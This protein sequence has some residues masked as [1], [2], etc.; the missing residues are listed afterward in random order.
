MNVDAWNVPESAAEELRFESL[1]RAYNNHRRART[2]RIVVIALTTA[3]VLARCTLPLTAWKDTF[4]DGPAMLGIA[5]LVTCL[6]VSMEWS[7]R[8]RYHDCAEAYD[9]YLAVHRVAH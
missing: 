8:V 5:F 3:A 6:S 2:I 7:S 1:E 4:V 9:R